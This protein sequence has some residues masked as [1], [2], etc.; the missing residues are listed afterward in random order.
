[1]HPHPW[2]PSRRQC[3]L[4]RHAKEPTVNLKAAMKDVAASATGANATGVA[5]AA[6]KAIAIPVAETAIQKHSAT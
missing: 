5:V 2:L 3:P 4:S 1:M 6:T